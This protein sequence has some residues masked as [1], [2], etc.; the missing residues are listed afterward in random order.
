MYRKQRGENEQ[1]YRAITI[2][3]SMAIDWI[4]CNRGY[5]TKTILSKGNSFHHG[6]FHTGYANRDDTGTTC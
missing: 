6:Y 1:P 2:F 5:I 4:I 3:V